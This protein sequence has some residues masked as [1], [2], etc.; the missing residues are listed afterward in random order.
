MPLGK[1]LRHLLAWCFALAGSSTK[2]TMNCRVRAVMTFDIKH[3]DPRMD[4]A[5]SVMNSKQIAVLV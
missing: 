5:E 4:C 3:L 1:W 2:A